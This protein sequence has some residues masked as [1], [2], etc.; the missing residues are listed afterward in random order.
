MIGQFPKNA[1]ERLKFCGSG[2]WTNRLHFFSKV[3]VNGRR[4]VLHR[5]PQGKIRTADANFFSKADEGQP[6][7]WSNP[8]HTQFFIWFFTKIRRAWICRILHAACNMRQVLT[9]K[10]FTGPKLYPCKLPHNLRFIINRD[11][12]PE[13]FPCCW[14]NITIESSNQ[15]QSINHKKQNH[16]FETKIRKI[17]IRRVHI[18]L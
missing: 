5:P 15:P 2:R 4:S 16:I 6:N 9:F 3:D 7:P 14:I 17:W 12:L 18:S 11:L 10:C 1:P 13:I 8:Y